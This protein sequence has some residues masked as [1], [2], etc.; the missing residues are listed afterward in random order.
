MGGH[1]T[2]SG[3][4]DRFKVDPAKKA[5][6]QAARSDRQAAAATYRDV[7]PPVTT[8]GYYYRQYTNGAIDI[9]PGSPMGVGR[10]LTSTGNNAKSWSLVTNEIGP[11]QAAVGAGFDL[12]NALT[13]LTQITSTVAPLVGGG[14][15]ATAYDPGMDM[16]PMAPEPAPSADIPM[17]AW[18]LGGVVVLGG[19][20]YFATKRKS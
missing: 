9:L 3:F 20:V 12:N 8:G 19:V 16:A 17:F 6:R 5:A 7:G 1:P 11:F 2:Y 18:L 14:A 10:R 13:A 15:Q 4:F